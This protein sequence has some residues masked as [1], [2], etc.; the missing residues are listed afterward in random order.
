MD[1][2]RYVRKQNI[3]ERESKYVQKKNKMVYTQNKKTQ[4]T[5]KEIKT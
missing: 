3:T 4:K 1:Y 2:T 5:Q